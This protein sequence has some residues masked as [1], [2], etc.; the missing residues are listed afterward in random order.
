MKKTF[1][2][3]TLVLCAA[4]YL[5]AEEIFND[6]MTREELSRLE[7]GETVIRN[8]DSYK[9][10]CMVSENA[11]AQRVLATVRS[12]KP[13]YVAEI[14]RLYPYEGNEDLPRTLAEQIA[15]VESY[16]G[17]P[18]YSEHG[19]KWY[20]LYSAASIISSR[21][22]E[23]GREILADLEMAPF[24]TINTLITIDVSP[25]G[26][27]YENM[28]LNVLRY[29]EKFKCVDEKK[30]RSSITVF[31]DGDNWVLYAVGAVSAPSIFFLRERAEISFMNRIRTFCTYFFSRQEQERGSLIQ[32]TG[33]GITKLPARISPTLT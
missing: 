17:I 20:D 3:I 8:L 25:D 22:T 12:I 6:R 15:D 14:I 4:L 32:Y 2:T 19:K 11:G 21:D 31:R 7:G 26:L 5:P 13:A 10:L 18:Y 28:N 30:M 24:G 16:V 23:T 27:Y 29:S 1:L 9:K 33:G